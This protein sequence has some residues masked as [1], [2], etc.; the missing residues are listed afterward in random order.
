[1][2]AIRRPRN[3]ASLQQ[4]ATLVVVLIMLVV[5]TLFAVAVI[6]LSNR[7]SRC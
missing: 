6:N 1:M 5:L 2:S 7:S 3:P 4:G